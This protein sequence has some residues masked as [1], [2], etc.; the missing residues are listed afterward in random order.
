M[1]APFIRLCEVYCLGSVKRDLAASVP[2]LHRSD[3]VR[4]TIVVRQIRKRTLANASSP[5]TI[6]MYKMGYVDH[7][8]GLQNEKTII[9][10]H[11]N[12]LQK[13]SLSRGRVSFALWRL[14]CG[15]H[16]GG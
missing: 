5:F 11:K 6:T 9:G 13:S 8:T 12:R 14:T 16:A 4:Q 2:L 1:R 3:R 15:N 10:R 7:L